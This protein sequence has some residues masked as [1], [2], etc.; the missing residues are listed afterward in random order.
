MSTFLVYLYKKKPFRALKHTNTH[1]PEHQILYSCAI[2]TKLSWPLFSLH[3]SLATIIPHAQ[4]TVGDYLSC[5]ACCGILSSVLS[6]LRDII[7]PAQRIA[8]YYSLCSAHCGI[9]SNIFSRSVLSYLS[10]F[11][12]VF[13]IIYPFFP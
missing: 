11:P 8:V 6:V 10:I 5:T 3:F 13:Y 2:L 1:T 12:V 9:L 7:Y 4:R